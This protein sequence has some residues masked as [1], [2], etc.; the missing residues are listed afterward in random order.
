MV[1]FPPF[2]SNS[3]GW[4]SWG[5]W[6]SQEAEEVQN[7][8][9]QTNNGQAARHQATG[10]AAAGH[11]GCCTGDNCKTNTGC[12][13][14]VK[15]YYFHNC[16]HDIVSIACYRKHTIQFV[17]IVLY[18]AQLNMLQLNCSDVICQCA[19]ARFQDRKCLT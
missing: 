11:T 1:L 19:T 15:C 8:L 14:D 13:C 17:Y 10:C 18:V 16:C 3:A 6:G 12:Y 5:G 4:G 7:Q 2:L 9:D